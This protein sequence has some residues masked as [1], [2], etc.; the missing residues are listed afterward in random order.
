MCYEKLMNRKKVNQS[1][2]S[3]D[4]HFEFANLLTGLTFKY[5]K[6]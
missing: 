1:N 3:V 4:M 6:E 5:N 2:Q